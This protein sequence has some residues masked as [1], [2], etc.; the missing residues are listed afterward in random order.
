MKFIA[1]ILCWLPMIECTPVGQAAPITNATSTTEKPAES[2]NILKLIALEFQQINA[3]NRKLVEGQE[4]LISQGNENK[5]ILSELETLKAELHALK[6][7]PKKESETNS[8][9]ES[10]EQLYTSPIDNCLGM[11]VASH[12]VFQEYTN[13][14]NITAKDCIKDLLTNLTEFCAPFFSGSTSSQAST[15]RINTRYFLASLLTSCF[16]KNED[17]CTHAEASIVIKCSESFTFAGR[18][19]FDEMLVDVNFLCCQAFLKNESISVY[20]KLTHFVGSKGISSLLLVSK[21]LHVSYDKYRSL[22]EEL[23]KTNWL[24]ELFFSQIFPVPA[25]YD[26]DFVPNQISFW[27][28]SF[29][30]ASIYGF[31]NS[32]FT[33]LH[34]MFIVVMFELLLKYIMS[35]VRGPAWVEHSLIL[36]FRWQIL[37]AL[38]WK[39]S[40]VGQTIQGFRKSVQFVPWICANIHTKYLQEIFMPS[41]DYTESDAQEVQVSFPDDTITMV[42]SETPTSTR[43]RR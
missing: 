25:C 20:Q 6:N 13:N 15:A 29:L 16:L 36:L 33:P 30:S 8:I 11:E 14:N 23:C 3:F 43:R 10:D 18:I 1:L 40:L 34:S 32:K 2:D 12:N 24:L 22:T 7:P 4:S 38:Y 27:C 5:L 42:V 31:S 19:F 9:V 28:I 35:I 41:S 21:S 17:N 39:A 37:I 26:K